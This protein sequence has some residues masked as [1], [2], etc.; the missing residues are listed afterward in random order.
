MNKITIEKYRKEWVNIYNLAKE[1]KITYK[2]LW[3]IVNKY[4]IPYIDVNKSKYFEY[5]IAH[6]IAEYIRKEE[7]FFNYLNENY[8]K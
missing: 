6:K 3:L 4:D 8:K 5:E 1:Y 2:R 7:D